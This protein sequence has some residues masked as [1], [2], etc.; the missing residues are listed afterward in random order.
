MI[1]FTPN[2]V[3]RS[4]EINSNFD[5]HEVRLDVLETAYVRQV[6]SSSFTSTTTIAFQDTGLKV[7]LPTAGT[8]IL[9]GDLR[10]GNA[11]NLNDYGTLRLYNQ[12]TSTAITDSDRIGGYPTAG[13]QSTISMT[14]IAVTTTVNNIVRVELKPQQARTVQL[15]SDS[16]GK[17][18]LIA[19]RIL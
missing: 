5:D 14:D 8:W 16:S 9:H 1:I 15:V 10:F 7:T 17:S 13:V 4:T 6:M 12:T 11:T 2:T 18:V 19:R 3:I